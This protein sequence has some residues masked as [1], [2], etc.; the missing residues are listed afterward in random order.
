MGTCDPPYPG[1][2]DPADAPDGLDRPVQPDDHLPRFGGPFVV[3][4]VHVEVLVGLE[5]QLRRYARRPGG[6]DPPVPGGSASGGGQPAGR[7]LREERCLP[8]QHSPVEDRS[9]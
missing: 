6:A 2:V 3:E 5:G 4:V 1:D 8:V 7:E 9:G